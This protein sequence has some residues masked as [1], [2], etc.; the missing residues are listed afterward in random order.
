MNCEICGLGD[1]KF[2]I[3]EIDGSAMRVCSECAAFGKIL[4]E[5]SA[6]GSTSRNS[7]RALE[8]MSELVLDPDYSA[9]LADALRKKDLKLEKLAEKIKESPDTLRK[10]FKGAITPTEETTKK[11]SGELGVKLIVEDIAGTGQKV[12]KR[13]PTFKDIVQIKKHK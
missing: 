13:E 11:L 8:N 10:I 1:K 6:D 7:I 5:L 3:A 9:I 4:S 12:D 2:Y